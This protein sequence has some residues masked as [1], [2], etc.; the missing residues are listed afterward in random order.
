[1]ERTLCIGLLSALLMYMGMVNAVPY[2][3][4]GRSCKDIGC[5][6]NEICVMETDP[7][8]IYSR[9][10][11]GSYPTCKRSEN[12]GLSC[13]TKICPTGQYCK[14]VNGNPTCVNS[15]PDI[16]PAA[17]RPSGGR[18]RPVVKPIRPPTPPPRSSSFGYGGRYPNSYGNS[19][20]IR[21]PL[22]NYGYNDKNV[23]RSGSRVQN[24]DSYKNDRNY[25]NTH[26]A[27]DNR[28][29]RIWTFS[30]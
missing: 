11:C 17:R 26:V 13:T 22:R 19:I 2:S 10:Q 8:T 12:S 21:D 9:D 28:G 6:S 5:R 20:G 27:T 7:C 24:T 16:A 23:G 14:T 1:M 30:G 29:N 3:K 15:S 25:Y 18:R 4:Y